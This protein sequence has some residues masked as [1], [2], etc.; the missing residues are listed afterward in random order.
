[1]FEQIL[2]STGIRAMFTK[3][4][5]HYLLTVS[6][7]LAAASFA[8]A[9]PGAYAAETAGTEKNS[10]L[11]TLLR[12]TKL[13]DPSYELKVAISSD[14]ILITTQKKLK[15]TEGE[16]KIQSVLLSKTAFDT[17]SSGQQRVK[18]MFMD[19]DSGGY[20]E[21]QVKRAEVL[22][23]GEG[24]LSQ[25]DLLSSL[26]VNSSHAAGETSGQSAVVSGIFQTERTMAL[27]RINRMK[28]AGTNVSPFMKLFEGVEE[29]A[30]K[31]DKEQVKLQ[32]TDL[33]RRLKDQEETLA[34]LAQRRRTSLQSTATA[35]HP[36]DVDGDHYHHRVNR[37]N[38]IP[39]AFAQIFNSVAETKI[40]T[41]PPDMRQTASRV[42]SELK[43]MADHD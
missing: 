14:E 6:F 10:Q 17:I 41:Y 15:A 33:N 1:M 11:V 9:I 2:R 12:N 40:A 32:L 24:K 25:K 31:D 3:R 28:A 27:E 13:I 39:N 22:L 37:G 4:I 18:L 8:L 34:G 38:D 43:F 5:S 26:E 7:L 21:V 16:L 42:L 35:S 23:F 19:F 20:S 30:K 29:A 36:I